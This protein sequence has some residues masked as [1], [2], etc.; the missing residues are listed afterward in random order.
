MLK[1]WDIDILLSLSIIG[2]YPRMNKCSIRLTLVDLQ[3]EEAKNGYHYAFT[4]SITY[5]C[6]KMAAKKN[7]VWGMETEIS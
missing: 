6:D 2:L 3:L 1:E 5:A 4:I 7:L